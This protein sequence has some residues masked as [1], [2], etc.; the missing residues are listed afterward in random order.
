MDTIRDFDAV[1][2][3]FTELSRGQLMEKSTVCTLTAAAAEMS[4]Q[5]AA[6]V[7]FDAYHPCGAWLKALKEEHPDAAAETAARLQKIRF[8]PV[9]QKK[10]IS[11]LGIVGIGFV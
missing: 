6:M 4:V 10:S 9:P 11:D 5:D 8:E 1:W 3:Q 2:E 7:W